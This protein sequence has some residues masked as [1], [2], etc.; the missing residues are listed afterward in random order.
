MLL[1]SIQNTGQK[2]GH[3][4]NYNWLTLD[5]TAGSIIAQPLKGCFW[6][7]ARLGHFPQTHFVSEDIQGF[8]TYHRLAE[9]IEYKD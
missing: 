6:F 1:G 8:F 5:N 2:M 9:T 4:R 3:M 7:L